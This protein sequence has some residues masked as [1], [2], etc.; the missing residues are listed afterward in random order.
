VIVKTSSESIAQQRHLPGRYHL[1]AFLD[2]VVS[3]E[4]SLEWGDNA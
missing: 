2:M 4:E 3:V 1:L